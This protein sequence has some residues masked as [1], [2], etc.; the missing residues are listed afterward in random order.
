[1]YFPDFPIL[2][3]GNIRFLY[4]GKNSFDKSKFMDS[5]D[6]HEIY[7]T[8]FSRTIQEVLIFPVTGLGIGKVQHYCTSK[9][10]VLYFFLF[11]FQTSGAEVELIIV[12][13]S[14]RGTLSCQN[15]SFIYLFPFIFI[16]APH[17]RCLM[18]NIG[19]YVLLPNGIII[20]NFFFF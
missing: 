2:H 10:K 18:C 17:H 11:F 20:L 6:Y 16:P 12:L 15:P 1:M 7:S 14:V 4:S 8:A 9:E 3:K 13:N 5:G 19:L